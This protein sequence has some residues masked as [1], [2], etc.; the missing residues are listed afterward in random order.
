MLRASSRLRVRGSSGAARIRAPAR[1]IAARQRSRPPITAASTSSFS[2]PPARAHRRF[3]DFRFRGIS[4]GVGRKHFV[5][6]RQPTP[7]AIRSGGGNLAQRQIFG[8]ARSRAFFRGA[9]Q[10]RQERAS[11]RIGTRG[12]AAEIRR[13]LARAA[14][15]LR[16]SADT[17]RGCAAGSRSGRSAFLRRPVSESAARSPLLPDPRPAPKRCRTDPNR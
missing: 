5:L 13:N 9:G 8:E 12:A 16:S 15:R 1:A 3:V 14:T 4:G 6:R 11:A 10:Q 7:R 2:Q 17:G